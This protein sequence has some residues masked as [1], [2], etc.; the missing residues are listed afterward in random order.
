[1]KQIQETLSLKPPMSSVPN[2]GGM[3]AIASHASRMLKDRC[4][5][6]IDEINRLLEKLK[7]RPCLY[8]DPEGRNL[9]VSMEADANR[10]F[11]YT[12]ANALL[13]AVRLIE[14]KELDTLR[15]CDCGEWYFASRS[16]QK[17]CSARC[18]QRRHASSPEFRATRRAYRK[19]VKEMKKKQ[20]KRR[21]IA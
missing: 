4:G 15:R 7:V 11:S 2:P 1:V 14:R 6:E 21:R 3:K 9:E 10:E 20:S 18:R 12:V 17:S 19:T 5:D 16:D 8:L 13:T